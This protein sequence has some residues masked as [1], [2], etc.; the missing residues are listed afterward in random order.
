V[1]WDKKPGT[2]RHYYYRSKRVDGRAVKTYIGPGEA[3]QKAALE[4]QRARQQR[5]S[6]RD[7]WETRIG[8]FDTAQEPT[9]DLVRIARLMM[10]VM[11]VAQGNYLH[12]GHEWRKRGG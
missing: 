3:G 4:D 7:W 11:L 2:K 5:A 6:D 10:R 12:K 1:S 9:D 8:E